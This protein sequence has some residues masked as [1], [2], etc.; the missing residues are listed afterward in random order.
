[1]AFLV[2]REN[3]EAADTRAEQQYWDP[4]R[5]MDAMLRWDPFRDTGPVSRRA[6]AFVPRFD[7]KETKDGYVFRADVPG[8]RESDI[9]ISVTGN[10]M[11]VT[12]RREA[13]R[14]NEGDQYYRME[15]SSGEFSRSFSLPDGT[16]LENV[17]ADLKDG[18]LTLTV[19]KKPEVQPRKIQIGK[20]S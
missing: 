11:T 13:E 7:V 8:V 6:D 10:V 3:R 16:D 12:G 4:F 20:G 18:V 9:D 1:M 14:L 17:K 19:A 5:V 2:R 15:R